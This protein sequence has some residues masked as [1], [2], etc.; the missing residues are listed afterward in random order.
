MCD[1]TCNQEGGK[2]YQLAACVTEEGGAAHT[3]NLLC[4]QCYNERQQKQGERAV[5]ASRRRE[6][7]GQK[8]FLRDIMGGFLAWGS[9]CEECGH[10]LR[11][12]KVWTILVLVEAGKERSSRHTKRSWSLSSTAVT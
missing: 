12:K 3:V 1:N 9:M 11:S 7:M 10:T 6:M 5:T 4:N 2:C 8:S